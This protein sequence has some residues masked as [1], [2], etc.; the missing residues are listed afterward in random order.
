MESRANV[1]AFAFPTFPITFHFAQ[2][3]VSMGRPGRIIPPAIGLV[4]VNLDDSEVTVCL[5]HEAP[6]HAA[7]WPPIACTIYRLGP[8]D[9]Q[10]AAFPI[11]RRL[12]RR[13][14][15]ARLFRLWS[16]FVEACLKLRE[17]RC[18]IGKADGNRLAIKVSD[19]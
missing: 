15:V 1:Y 4:V 12:L 11:W 16:S 18:G 5:Y 8:T 9:F 2:T 19:F 6:V 7:V 13:K 10:N 3:C 17:R 14:I